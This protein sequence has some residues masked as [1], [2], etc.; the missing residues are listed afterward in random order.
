MRIISANGYELARISAD[1]NSADQT[2]LIQA[3]PSINALTA[4]YTIPSRATD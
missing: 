1:A 4:A 2:A 3:Q